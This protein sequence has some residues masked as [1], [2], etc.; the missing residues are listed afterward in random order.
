MRPHTDHLHDTT[1]RALLNKLS[2]TNAGFDVQQAPNG[3]AALA[4]VRLVVR[5]APRIFSSFSAF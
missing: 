3:V 2:G 5:L 1:D 4:L